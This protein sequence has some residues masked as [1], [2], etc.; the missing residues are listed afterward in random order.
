MM[1]TVVQ[2]IMSI[3]TKNLLGCLS[4][5]GAGL[6]RQEWAYWWWTAFID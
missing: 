6:L 1:M 4:S 5:L 2:M 3:V